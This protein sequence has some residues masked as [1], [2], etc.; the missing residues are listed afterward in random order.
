METEREQQS[1]QESTRARE[2]QTERD[3]ARTRETR[4]QRTR[5][6]RLS[7]RQVEKAG[8]DQPGQ[9]RRRSLGDPPSE[10][11]RRRTRVGGGRRQVSDWAR[12]KRE[13][14][15]GRTDANGARPETDLPMQRLRR[16]GKA[17]YRCECEST[18]LSQMSVRVSSCQGSATADGGYEVRREAATSPAASRGG[19]EGKHH[20][21][22]P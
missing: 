18:Y 17:A 15:G 13:G 11:A 22:S 10:R 9:R 8:K 7:E 1:E 14:G 21:R 6:E 20:R 16:R 12:L 5:R 3:K 2:K 19:R 4:E